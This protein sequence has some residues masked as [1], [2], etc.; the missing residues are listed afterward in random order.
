MM[1]NIIVDILQAAG[2]IVPTIRIVDVGA[3]PIDGPCV[4]APLL[5]HPKLDDD[6]YLATVIGFEPNAEALQIL[7]DA[8]CEN[9]SY[10]PFA[11]GS[12]G[13]VEDPGL[14]S[15]NFCQAPGMT[16]RYKLNVDLMKHFP[17]FEKWGRTTFS[18]KTKC[19]TLDDAI[20]AGLI[21]FLKIDIQGGEWKVFQGA[22]EALHRAVFVQTEAMFLRM[23]EGQPLFHD[24]D[25][26]LDVAG[27][28]LHTILQPVVRGIGPVGLKLRGSP[29]TGVKQM[30]QA[31]VV[32]TR[33]LEDIAAAVTVDK[34]RGSVGSKLTSDQLLKTAIIADACYGSFDLAHFALQAY[35]ARREDEAGLADAYLEHLTTTQPGVFK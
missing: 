35:D 33:R 27:F 32:Y 34:A 16:S 21:D 22:G 15:I 8:K 24:L 19:V 20:G 10:L 14:M 17:M 28:Q 6:R 1:S 2:V 3:N 11:V 26:Q 30:L 18:S 4:Y 9:E 31:D 23:Y 13:S 5:K 29:F 12:G 7:N 25:Q